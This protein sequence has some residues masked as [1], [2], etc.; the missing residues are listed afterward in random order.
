LKVRLDENVS[1]RLARALQ[2]F[3]SGKNDVNLTWVRDF[4]PPGTKDPSW[5]KAFADEGGHAVVSGDA[6]I[7]QHWPDLVAYTESGLISYFPPTAW[8]RMKGYSKAAH[9][10]NWWPVL[11]E[12]MKV[13]ERGSRW[14]FPFLWTPC[15]TR[16][17]PLK[18][19]RIDNA[20]KQKA[21]GIVPVA[22]L[23]QIRP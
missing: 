17:E 5:I 21:R 15:P 14:R 10:I 11:H 4:A 9:L 6:N 16:L 13:A 1:V 8:N 19:P 2:A 23:H 12:H 20:G 22:T 18:D 7:L 3:W